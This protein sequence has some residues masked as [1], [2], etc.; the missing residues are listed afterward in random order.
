[1][2]QTEW[3]PTNLCINDCVRT[4]RTSGL[5]LEKAFQ[6]GTGSGPIWLD[7]LKCYGFGSDVRLANCRHNGWGVHNCCHQEDVSIRCFEDCTKGR[8]FLIAIVLYWHEYKISKCKYTLVTYVNILTTRRLA[9]VK[10]LK[11]STCIAPCMVYELLYS[12][13]ALI[14]QFN[15]QRTPCLPLPRKRSPDGASTDGGG[16][17]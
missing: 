2:F 15:L 5:F 6:Y 9:K 10:K 7:D 11:Q 3:L 12:I 8:Q 4:C 17:I 16:D 13:Q 14:T 1:M